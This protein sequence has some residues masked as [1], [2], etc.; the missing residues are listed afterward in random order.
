MGRRSSIKTKSKPVPVSKTPPTKPQVINQQPSMM[1]NIG[2][3]MSLGAGA[4][5]GS[6]MIHGAI[7][8]LSPGEE[9]KINPC[10][11]VMKQ[12]QECS[13]VNTDLN[14]CKPFLD[15]Y[16]NCISHNNL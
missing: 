16:S 15:Y 2:Q 11:D 10:E 6:T 9:K 4:A 5:I 7:G 1:G 14:I 12:F 3:G 8:A 13:R